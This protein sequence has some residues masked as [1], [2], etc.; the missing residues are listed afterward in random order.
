MWLRLT[1]IML[2]E[3]NQTQKSTYYNDCFYIK[4]KTRKDQINAI[5]SQEGDF[6]GGEGGGRQQTQRR[7]LGPD[8]VWFLVFECGLH[9]CV[10]STEIHQSFTFICNM[11]F[12]CVCILYFSKRPK[13]KL[14]HC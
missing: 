3:K 13:E 9:G 10:Q 1:Y 8:N 11:Y 6:P 12:V 4:Y 5:R 2:S 7:D 14:V